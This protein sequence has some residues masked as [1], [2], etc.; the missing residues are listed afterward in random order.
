MDPGILTAVDQFCPSKGGIL[1]WTGYLTAEQIE[2]IK[3]EVNIVK[4]VE[5][6][7]KLDTFLTLDRRQQAEN[8]ATGKDLP[9]ETID[10]PR[11]RRGNSFSKRDIVMKQQNA[12]PSLSFL[13][14]GEGKMNTG[15]YS[16]FV[17]SGR[18]VKLFY[19]GPGL[20]EAHPEF[21]SLHNGRVRW[22]Y[23][24]GSD[25]RQGDSSPIGHGTCMASILAGETF[26][27]ARGL[28]TLMAVKVGFDLS[29]MLDA[30][31]LVFSRLETD[32]TLEEVQGYT[33]ICFPYGFRELNED[34]HLNTRFAVH[35]LM[36]GLIEIYDAVLVVSVGQDSVFT[37]KKADD[38]PPINTFP[39]LIAAELPIITV[40]AVRVNPG[41]ADN[42]QRYPRSPGGPL[43]AV[44][45]P[46]KGECL[47]GTAS[48]TALATAYAAGLVAYLLSLRDVGEYLR[49]GMGDGVVP[50]SVKQH[51]RKTAFSRFEGSWPV[52]LAE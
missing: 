28:S 49:A 41:G 18:T 8:P 24:L 40:G 43:L 3:K 32:W 39:A 15:T 31:R 16:Y 45:A 21:W 36:E 10:T 27:V 19:L 42:G 51:L 44:S 22:A 47:G 34:Q 38:Y 37:Q 23:A 50:A 7:I 9:G 25:Y 33:V 11:S 46:G 20:N 26:G 12:D 6:D 48:G 13:S 30:F 52:F 4:A 5:P 17:P 2:L 29:S 14:T 35:R 1:F